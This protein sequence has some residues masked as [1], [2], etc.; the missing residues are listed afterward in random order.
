LI[1]LKL[2]ANENLVQMGR[3]MRATVGKQT[4]ATAAAASLVTGGLASAKI[5]PEGIQ[6]QQG[7]KQNPII[8]E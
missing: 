8:G 1:E 4:N 6:Q 2:K 7:R 3:T 5:L